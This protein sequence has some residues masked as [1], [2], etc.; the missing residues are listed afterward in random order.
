MVPPFSGL[1]HSDTVFLIKCRVKDFTLKLLYLITQRIYID[2]L[3]CGMIKYTLFI[4][5][6]THY[7]RMPTV[8]HVFVLITLVW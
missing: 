3:Y 8:C 7:E 1:P 6:R 2:I 5:I 4:N